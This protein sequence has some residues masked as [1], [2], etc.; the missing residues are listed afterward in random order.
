MLENYNKIRAE[1]YNHQRLNKT[2]T[3]DLLTSMQ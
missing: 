1:I 3:R 2:R